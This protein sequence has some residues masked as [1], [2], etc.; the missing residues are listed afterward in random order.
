MGGMVHRW[1]FFLVEKPHVRMLRLHS[2]CQCL[3]TIVRIVIGWN[4]CDRRFPCIKCVVERWTRAEYM[5]ER[6][7]LMIHPLLNQRRHFLWLGREA[8]CNKTDVQ[9][10]CRGNRVELGGHESIRG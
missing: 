5:N 3:A 4:G 2:Q 10:E 1:S 8:A 9:R 7:T 6:K